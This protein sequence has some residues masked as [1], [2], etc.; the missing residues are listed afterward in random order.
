MHAA[1]EVEEFWQE[2]RAQAVV[3]PENRVRA[4]SRQINQTAELANG[5]FEAQKALTSSGDAAPLLPFPHR[6]MLPTVSPSNVF[7]APCTWTFRVRRSSRPH[8]RRRFVARDVPHFL[9]RAFL[10]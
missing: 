7:S 8:T 2:E 5:E 4:E 9:R 3:T 1:E 6:I 10:H